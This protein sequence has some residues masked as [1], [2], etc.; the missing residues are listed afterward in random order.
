MVPTFL[1]LKQR[2]GRAEPLFVVFS[3]QSAWERR[4]LD[5]PSAP[6]LFSFARFVVLWVLTGVRRGGQR[7]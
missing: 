3:R 7:G 4:R 1:T 5:T 2:A 6:S